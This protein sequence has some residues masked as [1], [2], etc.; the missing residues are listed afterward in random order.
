[1]QKTK[2]EKKPRNMQ[3]KKIRKKKKFKIMFY[4]YDYNIIRH[5]TSV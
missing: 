5:L 2:M 4:N 3:L 1:M